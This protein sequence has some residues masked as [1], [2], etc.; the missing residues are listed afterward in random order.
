M[1]A[2]TSLTPDTP[3]TPEATA[4]WQ[5]AAVYQI[6][7]RSFCDSNGDGIGDLRGITSKLDYLQA[8][9][10]QVVWLS[11]VYQ[12]P[13]DDNGYDIS[14][15]RAVMP[16]FGT[17]ADFDEMLAGM[18]QRGIKLMMDLVVNHSS[19][20]HEWFKQ[21]RSSRSNPYHD[22]YIWAEPV[23]G[24]EP[25]NWESFF[26]G[27][28]WQWNEPTG[29]YY[30]HLFSRK[31]PDLNWENPAVR[32]EVF[33][34]MRFWLDKGVDGFR[35]DVINLIS[36]HWGADGRL[37]D[38][39]VV[40]EGFLQPGFDLTVNG[41][42]LLEFLGDMRREVLDHYPGCITVGE[43]PG[44]G[45]DMARAI[46]HRDTGPLNMVFQFDHM[47]LDQQPGQ[48]KWALKP[49]DWRDLKYSLNHWQQALA[50]TGWNSLY[51]CNHDQPRIVSRFGNDGPWRVQSAKMLATCLHGMQGTPYVYQGEELGMT[52]YPFERIEQCQDIE[53]L[54][55]YRE[56][57]TEQGQSPEQVMAAIR[58]KGR[59]NARTPM[60]WGAGAQAGFT[61][62][63]PWLAVNPNHTQINAE[64]ALADAGSV[65][66]HY[67]QLI[68]LRQ[69]QPALVHGRFELLAADH[70]QVLA[71]RRV[72]GDEQI[73]VICHVG[74]AAC[75]LDVTGW[76][77]ANAQLLLANW[78]ARPALTDVLALRPY[79][80]LML[81]L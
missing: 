20:E 51:F 17:M 23:D 24:R 48:S 19:D 25:T 36:K 9:G 37:P 62:G 59:D 78:P 71:Y 13:N 49:L 56:A 61:T 32:R 79:E 66:H 33:E 35:M 18:H 45:V 40:R 58:A 52:N 28:A 8:L 43:C 69:Q 75:E 22:H 46:T 27:S 6:Y 65:F 57:T 74:E 63:T 44:V 60:Q 53:S 39:P 15:Y 30:L 70:P 3:N 31:Q 4:W 42:R 34:L 77:L 41:P 16:E 81:K 54:N 80:A 5:R 11:P 38:A 10:V 55:M 50:G 76:G 1:N 12:S 7:P 21:A 64:A 73:V 14:D 68:A 26:S 67:R 72:L 29:E 47:S 2:I